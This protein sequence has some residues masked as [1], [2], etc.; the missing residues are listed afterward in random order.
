[1]I[2]IVASAVVLCLAVHALAD[3]PPATYV[4]GTVKST[5]L[6][7]LSRRVTWSN[8]YVLWGDA[9]PA[10][11]PSSS[12][13]FDF[14]LPPGDFELWGYGTDTYERRKPLHIDPGQKRVEVEF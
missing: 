7:Q 13:R 3:P 9:R 10:Q 2:R 14:L 6:Q 12:R 4:K 11:S 1:M 8:V 5:G